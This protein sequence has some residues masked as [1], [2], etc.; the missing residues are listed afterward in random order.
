M[1]EEICEESEQLIGRYNEYRFTFRTRLANWYLE[2][3][4]FTKAVEIIS[5]LHED[6]GRAFGKDS[7]KT[8]EYEHML[9]FAYAEQGDFHSALP[10]IE[11]AYNSRLS[12]LGASDT[13]T[14]QSK[15]NLA[16]TLL[17][18]NDPDGA[19]PLMVEA[20]NDDHMNSDEMT[21]MQLNLAYAYHM[22][23]DFTAA[24]KTYLLARKTCQ[25]DPD[26]YA[27]KLNFVN[28][29]ISS[30]RAFLRQPDKNSCS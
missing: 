11:H 28:Q 21:D 14:L 26:A 23:N 3:R 17:K 13:A 12:T 24:L 6:S 16:F 19:I 29:Q 2:D 25:Q 4:N 8:L 10:F 30:L 5:A 18:L 9:A 15:Y 7:K 22:Q 20:L 27:E 1:L